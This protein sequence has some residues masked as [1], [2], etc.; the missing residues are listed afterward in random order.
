MEE[1]SDEKAPLLESGDKPAQQST[2]TPTEDQS[3]IA[4]CT[5]ESGD[6]SDEKEID[7]SALQQLDALD[8]EMALITEYW[9]NLLVIRKMIN[10]TDFQGMAQRKPINRRVLCNNMSALM[11][12]VSDEESNF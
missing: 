8:L 7:D 3:S 4:Q 12:F 6:A 10:F 9:I 11:N 1:A 5:E 2:D